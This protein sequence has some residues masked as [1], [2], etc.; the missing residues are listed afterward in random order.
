MRV[1]S[2]LKPHGVRGDF[3][4]YLETDFP[5]WLANSKAFF[6]ESTAGMERWVIQHA[7]YDGKRFIAKVE[8]LP[9]RTAVEQQRG[10]ALFL[11]E[12]EARQASSDPDYFFNTDLVG[13]DVYDLL[14]QRELGKVQA[15]IEMP[16]QNL[17]EIARPAKQPLL[18]PFVQPIV[19]EVENGRIEVRLPAG[20]EACF[21]EDGEKPKTAKTRKPSA[22]TP[23]K[24]S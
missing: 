12:E 21:D 11:P 9:D 15:V 4:V 7:R 22:Q 2:V 16:A 5:E 14:S 8:S 17:L 19:A 23:S 13:C 24:K 1:G 18:I 10:T 20:L 6:I 3:F